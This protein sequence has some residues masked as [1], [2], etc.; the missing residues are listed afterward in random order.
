MATIGES[1]S[2]RHRIK[3]LLE[4]SKGESIP[5][6]IQMFFE[7]LLEEG[8]YEEIRL[9]LLQEDLSG[10]ALEVYKRLDAPKSP[11]RSGLILRAQQ[12][13]YHWTD[14][15]TYGKN[16]LGKDDPVKAI[17]L[18]FEL[19]LS[20]HRKSHVDVAV[21]AYPDGTQFVCLGMYHGIQMVSRKI[22]TTGKQA[23]PLLWLSENPLGFTK[24]QYKQVLRDAFTDAL[25]KDIISKEK[26]MLYCDVAIEYGK[27]VQDSTVRSRAKK[28]FEKAGFPFP[29]LQGYDHIEKE[30]KSNESFPE[31]PRNPLVYSHVF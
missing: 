11:I 19:Y 7:T 12:K 3:Q 15:E 2:I 30:P 20:L 27:N 18:A 24:E 9:R 8:E 23:I 10:T 4:E 31:L 17:L 16:R 22:E 1:C 14:E 29:P 13:K 25:H 6:Y 5:R 21:Y 28:K 26:F